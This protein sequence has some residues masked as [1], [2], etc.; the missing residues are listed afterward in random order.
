[1]LSECY[2]ATC[3]LWNKECAFSENERTV[4]VKQIQ[5]KQCNADKREQIGLFFLFLAAKN[6]QQPFL[7]YIDIVWEKEKNL[8]FLVRFNERKMGRRNKRKSLFPLLAQQLTRSILRLARFS[9]GEGKSL[10]QNKICLIDIGDFADRQS[11]GLELLFLVSS[12]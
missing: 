8:A 1:M 11:G 6:D 7:F 10:T 9:E 12:F 4:S 3:D 2:K 5:E